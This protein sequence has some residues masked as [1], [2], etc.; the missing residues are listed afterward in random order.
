VLLLPDD[1]SDYLRGRRRQ[2]LRTNLTRAASAGISCAVVKD[3]SSVLDEIF[4]MDRQRT[5]SPEVDVESWRAALTG[6]EVT[7]LVARNE[8]GNPLAYSGVVID[9][10]V[11]LMAH[12]GAISHEARWALHDYLVQILIA[13][14]VRYLIAS[15]GGL[16][17]A[18]GYPANVQQYQHLLGYEL[19]HVSA[20]A[21]HAL[22]P[23]TRWF[24]ER[25]GIR[26]GSLAVSTRPRGLATKRGDG[27][28]VQRG[29]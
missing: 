28:G 16:F 4:E 26:V 29:T 17:G 7:V 25:L 21:P 27:D 23:G 12:A 1:H 13:R 6:P 3:H 2:A 22:R 8:L 19:R 20:I 11:C 9:E 15:D 18:L 10:V 5:A 24:P 14:G